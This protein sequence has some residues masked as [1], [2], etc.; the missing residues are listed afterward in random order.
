MYTKI[1]VYHLTASESE[2]M[3]MNIAAESVYIISSAHTENG[4]M[5]DNKSFRIIVFIVFTANYI[6]QH[7]STCT[8]VSSMFNG[9]LSIIK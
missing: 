4:N 2:N 8:Y 3:R 7:P 5:I 6:L 9:A 1:F